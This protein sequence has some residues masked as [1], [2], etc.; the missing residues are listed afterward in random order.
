MPSVYSGIPLPSHVGADCVPVALMGGTLT[1]I[2]NQ[3]V[4]IQYMLFGVSERL[5]SG[6]SVYARCWVLRDRN[7]PGLGPAD[8]LFLWTFS[9]SHHSWLGEGTARTLRTTQWTRAS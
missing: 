9:Q 8:D 4:L 7:I 2:Q 1:L 5:V 3:E 6:G